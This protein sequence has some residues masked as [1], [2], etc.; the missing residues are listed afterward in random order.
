MGSAVDVVSTTAVRG[1]RKVAHSASQ[2]TAGLTFDERE[3]GSLGEPESSS[4]PLAIDPRFYP[5][6]AEAFAVCRGG[7]FIVAT[8]RDEVVHRG[9]AVIRLEVFRAAEAALG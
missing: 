6:V 9:R 7:P 8:Q 3:S 1:S 2:N 4:E 5:V